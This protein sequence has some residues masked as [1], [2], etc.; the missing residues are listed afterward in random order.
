MP[1]VSCSN[2][3]VMDAMAKTLVDD[4][5]LGKQWELH[6][7]RAVQAFSFASFSDFSVYYVSHSIVST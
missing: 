4:V 1:V 2:P 3:G 6:V 7:I 5:V